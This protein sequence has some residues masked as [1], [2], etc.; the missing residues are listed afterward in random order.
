MSRKSGYDELNSSRIVAGLV[1]VMHANCSFPSC[2]EMNCACLCVKS[3]KF[4]AKCSPNL[5]K[6]HV[7]GVVE[8]SNKESQ[9]RTKN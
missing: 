7:E 2:V 1:P 8:E 6:E 4:M 5:N 9:I 3:M